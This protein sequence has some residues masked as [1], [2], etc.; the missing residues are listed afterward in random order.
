MKL[1][2]DDFQNLIKY[3]CLANELVDK[4]VNIP[5]KYYDPETGLFREEL[6]FKNRPSY[7]GIPSKFPIR[8]DDAIHLAKIRY[9]CLFS[10]KTIKHT[11]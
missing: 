3:S 8:D 1:N 4:F 11:Y 7:R 10:V 6:I 9:S 5:Q 2:T